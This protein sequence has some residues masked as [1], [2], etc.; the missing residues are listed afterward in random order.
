M[1]KRYRTTITNASVVATSPNALIQLGDVAP[2]LNA[3]Y[4]LDDDDAIDQNTPFVWWQRSKANTM[5]SPMPEPVHGLTTIQTEQWQLAEILH[6][7]GSWKGLDVPFSTAAGDR[8]DGRGR[9]ISNLWRLH[10][11]T[12]S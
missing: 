1:T 5:A 2:I 7:F 9:V 8:T 12:E 11:G 3:F 10:W 4:D 6:W